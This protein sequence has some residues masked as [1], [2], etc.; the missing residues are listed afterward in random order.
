M[1]FPYVKK[2]YCALL[3][4]TTGPTGENQFQV[5]TQVGEETWNLIFS[6]D[7][8][9]LRTA[10]SKIDYVYL[11]E[12]SIFG[13]FHK[14]YHLEQIEP[15]KFKGSDLKDAIDWAQREMQI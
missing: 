10:V 5:E 6:Q 1:E 2:Y 4:P 7:S 11:V 14:K 9:K 8:L 15:I 3:N 12:S 13:L